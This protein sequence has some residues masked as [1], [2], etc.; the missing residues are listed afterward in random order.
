M[1]NYVGRHILLDCYGC[2]KNQ[3]NSRDALISIIH[4]VAK[5]IHTPMNHIQEFGNDDEIIIT[6]LK[7]ITPISHRCLSRLNYVVADVYTFTSESILIRL[8]NITRKA[9]K[10]EKIRA[11]SVRRGNIDAHPDMGSLRPNP[12]LQPSRKVKNMG[13]QINQA[14]KKFVSTI[15]KQNI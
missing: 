15:R 9:L 7:V 6:G 12:K 3:V 14:R 11:T 5:T 4:E 2:N 1:S 8:C 13:R 10:A